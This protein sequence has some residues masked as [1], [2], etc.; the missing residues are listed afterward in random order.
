[1]S[2]GK[3]NRLYSN[4]GYLTPEKRCSKGPKE[5]RYLHPQASRQTSRQDSVQTALFPT[6]NPSGPIVLE[7]FAKNIPEVIIYSHK[8]LTTTYHTLLTDKIKSARQSLQSF[9]AH[10][11]SHRLKTLENNQK[12]TDNK[13]KNISEGLNKIT[14]L[15]E[16]LKNLKQSFKDKF[17]MKL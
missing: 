16:S 9:N 5:Y 14:Q 7:Y 12:L 15:S 6:D 11:H 2:V 1:M 8:T 10:M 3:M 17:Y 4:Q 13:I